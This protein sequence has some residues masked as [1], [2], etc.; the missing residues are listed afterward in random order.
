MVGDCPNGPIK[1]KQTLLRSGCHAGSTS[2]EATNEIM[3]RS[4]APDT[5]LDR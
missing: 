4:R 3:D 5:Y 2:V 1:S